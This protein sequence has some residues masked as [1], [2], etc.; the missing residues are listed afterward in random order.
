M[1]EILN[2]GQ[3]IALEVLHAATHAGETFAE[4]EVVS[5]IRFWRFAGGPIP[6]AA[7]LEITDAAGGTARVTQADLV[8]SN[9]VIHVTD[10]VSLPM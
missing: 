3:V 4:A 6:I 8:Q 9:G 7:V 2:E 1:V 5:G 10:A